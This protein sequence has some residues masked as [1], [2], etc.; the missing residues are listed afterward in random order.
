M[1]TKNRSRVVSK[2]FTDT[3][4]RRCC[5][6]WK[7][8]QNNG[9]TFKMFC[10]NAKLAENTMRNWLR[11]FNMPMPAG[12]RAKNKTTTRRTMTTMS[13]VG[14]RRNMNTGR[15]MKKSNARNNNAMANTVKVKA[16][17]KNAKAKN[18]TRAKAQKNTR[19]A[20]AKR[21]AR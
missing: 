5:A 2:M 6:A 1:R 9:M 10:K 7:Q 15:K 20:N 8:A 19:R 12:S 11:K 16:K 18:T 4:R 13:T 14:T 21:T 3:Q 17:A